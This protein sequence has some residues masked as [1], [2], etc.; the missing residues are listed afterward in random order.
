[1]ARRF[2]RRQR[3]RATWWPADWGGAVLDTSAQATC[4]PVPGAEELALKILPPK[5]CQ[6]LLPRE[7]LS[8]A[9]PALSGRSVIVLLASGGFGKTQ[10]LGQ[11]YRQAWR[12]AELAAWL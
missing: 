11:W 3:R 2:M 7:R 8:L 4:S 6:G 1:M 12:K 5:Y 10:L 9:D